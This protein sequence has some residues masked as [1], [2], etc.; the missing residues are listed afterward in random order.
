MV[1]GGSSVCGFIWRGPGLLLFV[2]RLTVRAF[3]IELR[4]E[5]CSPKILRGNSSISQSD[6]RVKNKRAAG[7]Q[8]YRH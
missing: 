8:T 2:S 5:C 4:L 6:L 1:A 7:G 3:D